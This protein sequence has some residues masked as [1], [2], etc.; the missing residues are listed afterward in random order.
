MIGATPSQPGRWNSG[1]LPL[2]AVSTNITVRATH[3]RGQPPRQ[4]RWVFVCI[5]TGEFGYLP[6]DELDI[7]GYHGS[8]QPQTWANAVEVGFSHAG[9]SYALGVQPKTSGTYN[10]LTNTNTRWALKCYADW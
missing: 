6:G 7:Y 10:N 2:P 5:G 8:V 9:A 3:G 1:L 4:V